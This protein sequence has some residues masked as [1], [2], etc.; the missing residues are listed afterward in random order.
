MPGQY[1]ILPYVAF[2]AGY[3]AAQRHSVAYMPDSSGHVPRAEGGVLPLS[4]SYHDYYADPVSDS[5]SGSAT[6]TTAEDAETRSDAQ[7]A[8]LIL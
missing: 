5:R 6:P 1:L 4:R 2:S 7:L 8:V 3:L